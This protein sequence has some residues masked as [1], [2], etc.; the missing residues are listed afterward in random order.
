MNAIKV[1]NN[2]Y[3]KIKSNIEAL[4]LEEI[5]KINEILRE[6]SSGENLHNH[7]DDYYKKTE[8][9]TILKNYSTVKHQHDG[10]Y[11]TKDE[12]ISAINDAIETNT[13]SDEIVI[14]RDKPINNEKLW[15][16]IID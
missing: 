11:Y 5:D 7:D 6:N 10:R 15:F 2:R 14:S 13:N 1:S 9:T 8:I 16:R 12:T 4:L 3:I